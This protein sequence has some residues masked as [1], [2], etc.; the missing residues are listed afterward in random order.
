MRRRRNR[1]RRLPYVVR[2]DSDL[3]A[4][5]PSVIGPPQSICAPEMRTISFHF[6]CSERI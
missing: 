6:G 1:K 2:A 3:R 5:R 4:R